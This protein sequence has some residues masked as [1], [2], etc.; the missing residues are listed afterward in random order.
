MLTSLEHAPKQVN[1]NFDCKNNDLT[2]LE[3]APKEV[4][5]ILNFSHNLIVSLEHAPIYVGRYFVCG[6]NSVSESVLK[7]IYKKMLSGMSWPDAVAS[8]WE[9][10]RKGEDK[11]LLAQYNPKLS[12]EDAKGYE[13]LA[14]FRNKII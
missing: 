2:S 8:Y 5:K 6:E 1:G 4:G 7:P 11:I 12:P 13:A 14:K 9:K 3:H 10:I